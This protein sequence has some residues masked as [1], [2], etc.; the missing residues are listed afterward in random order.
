MYVPGLLSASDN[1]ILTASLSGSRCRNV[2]D[3]QGTFNGKV[4]TAVSPHFNLQTLVAWSLDVG[5]GRGHCFWLPVFFYQ[6][7]DLLLA[8]DASQA[9]YARTWFADCLRGTQ[10]GGLLREGTNRS[11]TL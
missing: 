4:F 8:V 5:T 11:V 7:N 10:G 6:A 2:P 1:S 9:D 3:I